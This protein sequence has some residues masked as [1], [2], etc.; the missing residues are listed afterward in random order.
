M[1]Y[2]YY[3]ENRHYYVLGKEISAG[4]EG[5]EGIVYKVDGEKN[6]VAKIFKAKDKERELKINFIANFKWNDEMQKY[7][8]LPEHPLYDNYG[9][10]VGYIM[11]NAKSEYTCTLNDAYSESIPISIY[12]KAYTAQELCKAVIAAHKYPSVAVGDFNADNIIVDRSTGKITMLDTDSLHIKVRKN[13][14]SFLFPC[15]VLD[16]QLFMPELIREFK[17]NRVQTIDELNKLG[18]PTFNHNT[19]NYCLAYH[20]HRLIMGSQP[21]ALAYVKGSKSNSVPSVPT[22]DIMAYQGIYPYVKRVEG[23]K[24]PNFFVDFDIIP[25]ELQQLFIRAFFFGSRN[26]NLRPKPEEFLKVLEDYTDNLEYCECDGFDHYLYKDYAPKTDHCE[27]CR[28]EKEKELHRFP[29]YEDLKFFTENELLHSCKIFPDLA[30]AFY[31]ELGNKYRDYKPKKALY[32]Y[33]MVI[34]SAKINSN[35]KFNSLVNGIVKKA[36]ENIQEL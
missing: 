24:I 4:A 23:T 22:A 18:K 34:S 2:T 31:Y 16:G 14:R 20:I 27:W 21:Y 11:K 9:Q 29:V 25:K 15:H 3:D 17:N 30:P 12:K 28:V 10:L 36:E 6:L 5:A 19:D 7:F 1:T 26:P 8:A 13:G 32:Y 35:H 33:Y